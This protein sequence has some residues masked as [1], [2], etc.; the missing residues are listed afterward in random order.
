[1]EDKRVDK[2]QSEDG[3][4]LPSFSLRATYHEPQR[5]PAEARDVSRKTK[6]DPSLSFIA[7]VSSKP[8]HLKKPPNTLLH[9]HTR[10]CS[11]YVAIKSLPVRNGEKVRRQRLASTVAAGI[12]FLR[13]V[14]YILYYYSSLGYVTR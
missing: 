9:T 3:S 4:P 6:W 14:S 5:P 10:G 1:M 2:R 12:C 8:K 13:N 11:E 7:Q